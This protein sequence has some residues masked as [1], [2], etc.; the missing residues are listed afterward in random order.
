MREIDSKQ[1]GPL[2]HSRVIQ[3]PI[4]FNFFSIDSSSKFESNFLPVTQILQKRAV[5]KVDNQ[6]TPGF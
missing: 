6:G 4:S 5:E 3:D 1:M 2:Y